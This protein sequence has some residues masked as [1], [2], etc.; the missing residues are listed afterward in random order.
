MLKQVKS[1]TGD[2]G[3]DL[4]SALARPGG[5]RAGPTGF[6]QTPEYGRFG[7]AC[8]SSVRTAVARPVTG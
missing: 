1:C 7:N 6:G 3:L 2:L 5:L 4:V 8:R